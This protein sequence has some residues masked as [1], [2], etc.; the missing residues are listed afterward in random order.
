MHK[1][2]ASSYKFIKKNTSRGNLYLNMS[3]TDEFLHFKH[4]RNKALD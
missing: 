3:A 4:S 1:D 2:T